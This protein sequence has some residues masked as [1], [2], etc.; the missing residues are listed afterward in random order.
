VRIVFCGGCNAGYDRVAAAETIKRQPQTD[1]AF[2]VTGDGASDI[3]VTICG[4]ACACIDDNVFGNARILRVT[5]ATSA[6]NVLALL[7]TPGQ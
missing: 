7:K 5:D 6:Q 4:C 2:E 3:V 1:V